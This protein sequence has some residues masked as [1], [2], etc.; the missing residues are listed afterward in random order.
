MTEGSESYFLSNRSGSKRFKRLKKH[1]DPIDRD[2]DSP[3]LGWEIKIY[4]HT[5]YPDIY[6]SGSKRFKKN[7]AAPVDPDPNSL[8]WSKKNKKRLKKSFTSSWIV[9]RAGLRDVL[10]AG[11]RDVLRAGLRDVLRTGLR[12]VLRTRLVDVLLT[13]LLVVVLVGLVLQA[14]LP[15]PVV[16]QTRLL[17][18]LHSVPT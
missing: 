6:G 16:L 18:V 8:H 3:T 17:A 11:L 4:I 9:L 7:Q 2:P 12:D 15:L 13:R 14:G 10:R 1:E 5:S